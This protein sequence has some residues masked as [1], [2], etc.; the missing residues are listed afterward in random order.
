MIKK[1]YL[2]RTD[3]G[4]HLC[5]GKPVKCK[6]FYMPIFKEIRYYTYSGADCIR[7]NEPLN[8]KMKIGEEPKKVRIK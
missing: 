3:E 7:I 1:I 8:I 4:Y 5:S 2:I 6:P